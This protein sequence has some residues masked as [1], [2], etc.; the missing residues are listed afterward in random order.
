MGTRITTRELYDKV[1]GV[2]KDV[3]LIRQGQTHQR[4]MNELKQKQQDERICRI[5]DG[6][7][8]VNERVSRVEKSIDA[9]LESIIT[10]LDNDKDALKSITFKLGLIVTVITTAAVAAINALIR[11]LIP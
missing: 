8:K 4:E 1:D 11:K 6:L 3:A 5:E 7:E 2:G 10:R 9:K